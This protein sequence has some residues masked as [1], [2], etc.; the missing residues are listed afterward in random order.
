MAQQLTDQPARLTRE[1]SDLPMQPL[2]PS[3]RSEHEPSLSRE[4][5][6]HTPAVIDCAAL[7]RRLPW[8]RPGYRLPPSASPRVSASK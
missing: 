3:I 7:R 5:F 1:S 4:I 6:A 2:N 8:Q